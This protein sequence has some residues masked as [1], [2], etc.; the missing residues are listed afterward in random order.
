LTAAAGKTRVYARSAVAFQLARSILA[1]AGSV[2]QRS[3][4]LKYGFIG[5]A[6]LLLL[7]FNVFPFFYTL[8]MSFTDMKPYGKYG[9]V[10]GE[11]YGEVFS[12][13][14]YA[15]SIRTT[16]VFVVAAVA[17]E[18]VVG[19]CL[20]LALRG[21]FRGKTAVL[22]VLL[23]P[24]ML[25]PAV[26][27]TFWGMILEENYGVLNKLLSG[28][29]LPKFG[30]ISDDK[31]R[32]FSVLLIDVW[33]W[34]PF[35]MLI[36]LAALNSIPKYIYEAAEIDRAGRWTVFWRITLPMCAPL[37]FLAVL[38]RTTDAIKQFDFVMALYGSNTASVQT[39]SARIYQTAI[40]EFKLGM[41]ASY[42]FVIL[43]AIIAL[44]TL[45]TR[46]VGYVQSKQGKAAA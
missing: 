17:V 43:V 24:M 1:T 30:W 10:G 25:A 26:M 2:G 19:F 32:L 44:A 22:T 42:G 37:L 46:Y 39:L 21:E 15:A 5:P 12:D 36:A 3:G 38:L 41:G 7:A 27:G 4:L 16:A 20:A 13:A 45:F 23:V 35:M 29:G 11:N 18:L 6:I 40:R 8:F 34:T 33:M 9:F 31:V 28:A 14:S